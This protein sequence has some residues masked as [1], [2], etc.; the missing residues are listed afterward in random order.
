[1]TAEEQYLGAVLLHPERV[2]EHNVR[3][4]DFVSLRCQRVYEAI[5]KTVD[6]GDRVDP[7]VLLHEIDVDPVWFASLTSEPV[8]NVKRLSE[9]VIEHGKKHRLSRLVREAGERLET[10]TTA[11][12]L[13]FIESGLSDIAE[14]RDDDLVMTGDLVTQMVDE[15]QR[16]YENHGEIPGITTGLADVDDLLLGFEKA[17][18]YV[19]GARPSDGKSALLLNL[20]I[21]AKE[22]QHKPGFLSLESSR[23]ET[24]ERSFASV[25]GIDM[26]ALRKGKLSNSMLHDM[27]VAAEWIRGNSFPLADRPNM[28]LSDLKARARRMVR[29][30]GCDILFVDYL[31]LVQMPGELTDYE[32]ISRVS[33]SLKDLSRELNIPIVVA[34]QLNRGAEDGKNRKPRLSE[35]KGTGQIEQDADAAILIYR[36]VKDDEEQFYLCVEKNRDGATG[37]V[38][39]YFDKA[40]M[41]F[42]GFAHGG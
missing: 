22:A 17:R 24:M 16:R 5:S 42:R 25:G 10:D 23:V 33:V 1:M 14:G 38:H 29:V 15:F 36:R 3:A 35:L 6:R 39:V 30:L 19:V 26:G 11:G 28:H 9:L 7:G 12:V 27:G 20:A 40:R 8:I 32:R 21:S 4:E 34:A 41:R 37:D 18:Y 2:F 31:Q 13:E